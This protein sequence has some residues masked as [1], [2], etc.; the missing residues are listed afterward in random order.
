MTS[1][2]LSTT[3]AFDCRPVS[4]RFVDRRIG[5]GVCVVQTGEI[6]WLPS[7]AREG[8]RS[9]AS[10]PPQICVPQ[11][12]RDPVPPCMQMINV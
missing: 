7:F 8:I 2:L 11:D 10:Q 12:H 1:T 6:R 5:A 4:R 9:V 3:A